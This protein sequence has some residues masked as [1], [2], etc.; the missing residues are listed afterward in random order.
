MGTLQ[1]TVPIKVAGG[2]L[3]VVLNSALHERGHTPVIFP[4]VF[5]T[6]YRTKKKIPF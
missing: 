2:Y 1:I 4:G 6:G 3:N 5:L